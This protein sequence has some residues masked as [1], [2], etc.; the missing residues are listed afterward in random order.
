MGL[1]RCSRLNTILTEDGRVYQPLLKKAF[2]RHTVDAP[3]CR[4]QPKM[5]TQTP[6][7]IK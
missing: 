2:A 7:L 3:E 5:H 6:K 1:S 4:M